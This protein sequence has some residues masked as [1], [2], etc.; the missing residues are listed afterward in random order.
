MIGAIAD[1]H[2]NVTVPSFVARYQINFPVGFVNPDS[3]R[4]LAALPEGMRPYVPL[5]MFVDAKGMVRQ[6]YYGNDL[7]MV[8]G[9]M[10]GTIRDTLGQ[11]LNDRLAPAK[12]KK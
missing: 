1:D 12:K 5:I 2:P 10:E 6:Q 8:N 3:I 9:K 11:L 7:V 4:R